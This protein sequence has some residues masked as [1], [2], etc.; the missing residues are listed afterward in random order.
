MARTPDAP[1]EAMAR[2]ILALEFVD[3]VDL[4]KLVE[5]GGPLPAAQ[6][7]DY[8]RQAAVGLQHAHEKGRRIYSH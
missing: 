5:K 6:A 7:V 3:G 2:L 4:E 8:I 1:N